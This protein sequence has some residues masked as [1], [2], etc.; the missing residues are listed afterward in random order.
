MHEDHQA[1]EKTRADAPAFY[2]ERSHALA[3]TVNVQSLY[4]E[5]QDLFIRLMEKSGLSVRRTGD[6]RPLLLR[7]E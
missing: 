5:I 3:L 7:P 1:F 2:S 6:R 4:S